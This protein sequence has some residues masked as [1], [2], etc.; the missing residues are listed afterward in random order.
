MNVKSA[1]GACIA[2]VP[3]LPMPVELTTSI[4][5]KSESVLVADEGLSAPTIKEVTKDA[6][7]IG[8]FKTIF[9]PKKLSPVVFNMLSAESLNSDVFMS[10]WSSTDVSKDFWIETASSFIRI[11]IKPRKHFF[12]PD[13]WDTPQLDVRDLLLEH[14]GKFA[15]PRVL[16][17]TL[18]SASKEGT[19]SGSRLE[20]RSRSVWVGRTVYCLESADSQ[21]SSEYLAR[22][23]LRNK[24]F[25]FLSAEKI[26]QDVCGAA[27]A[28]RKRQITG[29]G[30]ASISLGGYARATFYGISKK[31][32]ENAHVLKY[33]NAFMK[34]HGAKGSGS[35]VALSHN[36]KPLVHRDQHN[37]KSSV[38]RTITFGAFSGG[39]LW[40][41][42][43]S[44]AQVHSHGSDFSKY[45]VEDSNGVSIEAYLVSTREN[46]FTFDPH[47][48]H[49]VEDWNG[50]RFT[51]TC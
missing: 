1:S 34:H 45:T 24:D 49:C 8:V 27:K 15:L 29:D 31:S 32:H 25:S 26:L 28:A 2:D 19:T 41:E 33:V 18:C 10:W 23:L 47:Q 51:I 6:S 5:P 11:H 16:L 21:V 22:E 38:N 14:I 44:C 17:A 36:I 20:I 43:P 12:Y 46:M 35:A 4:P 30:S 37:E 50:D 9:Y 13:M 42:S 7:D 48:K 39:R 40:L 3:A